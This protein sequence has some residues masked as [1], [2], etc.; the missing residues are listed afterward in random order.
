MS[1]K[2]CCA[3]A[4]LY[5]F[6]VRQNTPKHN[7]FWT[8]LALHAYLCT[9]LPVLGK[10]KCPK[11]QYFL[12]QFCVTCLPVRPFTQYCG[13]IGSK[14]VVLWGI[15]GLPKTRKGVRRQACK[16]KLVQNMLLFGVFLTYPKHV[17][18]CADRRVK[19]NWFKK[20]CALGYFW[21]TQ[22]T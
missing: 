1:S 10:A 17:K 2:K 18:G 13:K 22:N 16:A 9:P 3:Q 4:P 8:N 11:A 14:N 5:L 6:W 21:L 12:N 15:F 20:C 19:Q 7:I